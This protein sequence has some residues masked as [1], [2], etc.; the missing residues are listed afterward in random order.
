MLFHGIRFIPVAVLILQQPPYDRKQYGRKTIP[1]A[2]IFSPDN[3][4][5]C[6]MVQRLQLG[7]L[8]GNTCGDVLVSK[9]NHGAKL[10]GIACVG[11]D[12][13]SQLTFGSCKKLAISKHKA[14]LTH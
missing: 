12:E 10:G 14:S 2:V 5:M 3:I 1:V 7:S 9:R 6:S 8:W 4:A 11:A 13:V